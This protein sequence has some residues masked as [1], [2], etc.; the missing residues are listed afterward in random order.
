MKLYRTSIFALSVIQIASCKS[1]KFNSDNSTATK[2]ISTTELDVNDVSFLFPI[3]KTK[4]EFSGLL[5]F[6]VVAT[7]GAALVPKNIFDQ[8]IAKSR[9]V[10]FDPEFS[11]LAGTPRPQFAAEYS[12]W[13]IVGFRFDPCA[14]STK[15]AEIR[16]ISELKNCLFEIRLI[17]QPFQPESSPQTPTGKPV[18]NAQKLNVFKTSDFAMHLIFEVPVENQASTLTQ[19]VSDLRVLK[20]SSSIETTGEPL[21]VHPTMSREGIGAEGKY[22][23]LL[24]QTILKYTG[25]TKLTSIAFSGLL[26]G[27]KSW[28]FMSVPVDSKTQTVGAHVK[29]PDLPSQRQANRMSGLSSCCTFDPP[30]ITEEPNMQTMGTFLI[31]TAQIKPGGDDLL[32]FQQDKANIQEF[33]Q[34]LKLSLKLENPSAQSQFEGNCVSCHVA[35]PFK[36]LSATN[37]NQDISQIAD[38]LTPN[39][40]T[41][42]ADLKSLNVSPWRV[43]NFGYLNEIPI[44]SQRTI[45]ESAAVADLVSRIVP[46]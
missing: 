42:K 13:R 29:I 36:H 10:S 46:E 4:E 45:N 44:I 5:N 38:Y 27:D 28:G 12:A 41:T 24:R 8:V 16:S 21:S 20:G 3:P 39:G 32:K 40:K 26:G 11:S 19:L 1:R 22:A 30:L 17:A 18:E 35:T 31:K 7:D 33:K 25:G 43:R 23:K 34:N 6:K 2:S 15:H 14:S 37:M 9:E